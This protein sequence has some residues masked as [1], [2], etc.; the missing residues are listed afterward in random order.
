[1]FAEDGLHRRRPFAALAGAVDIRVLRQQGFDEGLPRARHSDDENRYG[2]RLRGILGRAGLPKHLFDIQH[3][4]SM[5]RQVVGHRL[6]HVLV[7]PLVIGRRFRVFA[8]FVVGLAKGEQKVGLVLLRHVL[9]CEQVLEH[10]DLGIAG[11]ERMHPGEIAV[12]FREMGPDFRGA[13]VTGGRPFHV[14]PVLEDVAEVVVRLGVVGI[15]LYGPVVG[16]LR[17][18]RIPLGFAHDS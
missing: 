10:V 5:A 6:G 11:N 1:M 13:P 15:D 16:G 3:P 9:A 14:V 8:D 2:L 18:L 12:R 17:R 4:L 7:R